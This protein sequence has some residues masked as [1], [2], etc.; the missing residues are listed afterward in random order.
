MSHD[1]SLRVNSTLLRKCMLF[2][3]LPWL[4]GTLACRQPVVHASRVVVIQPLGNFPLSVANKVYNELKSVHR[5]LI[6]RPSI[7]FPAHAWYAP[8]NRYW[9]DSLIAH[10]QQFGNS[11]TVIIGLSAYDISVTKGDV[12]DWGVMGLGYCPG[13]ACV[14]STFRLTKQRQQ[15][16]FYK[17]AIHE[18]GH[19]QGLPHCSEATCYMR[20]AAGGNPL[21][22]EHSFCSDCKSFLVSKGWQLE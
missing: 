11:D 2:L 3:L 17:V 21:D 22:E 18:L 13:H 20:D 7:P 14:V 6:L 16:Q 19:T 8:R 12:K 10:L 9:A 1:E 15:Q 4:S 5:D